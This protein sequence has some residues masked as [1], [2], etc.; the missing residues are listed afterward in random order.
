[1]KTAE[2]G[3]VFEAT[4]NCYFKPNHAKM[5]RFCGQVQTVIAPEIGE[6]LRAA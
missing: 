3:E 1:M 6:K 5:G 4:A 2:I